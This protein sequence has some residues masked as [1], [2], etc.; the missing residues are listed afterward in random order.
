[1]QYIIISW[2]NLKSTLQRMIL[3]A[4]LPSKQI[5]SILRKYWW[6]CWSCWRYCW[7]CR[8]KCW[9][10]GHY[11]DII[12]DNGE[13]IANHMNPYLAADLNLPESGNLEDD[14]S[15]SKSRTSSVR[16]NQ[17]RIRSIKSSRENE[18]LRGEISNKDLLIKI[19]SES[20]SQITNY[21][22]KSNNVRHPRPQRIFLL[23][24]MKMKKK[25]VR[26]F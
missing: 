5:L 2:K 8:W 10:S 18:T 11:K 24:E 4:R 12:D 17:D 21:F 26:Q 23:N 6:Y 1:M 19:V 25:T 13:Y 20:L 15:I 7:M 3:P 16:W 22:N 9:R 14:N